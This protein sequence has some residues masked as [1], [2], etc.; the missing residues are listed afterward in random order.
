MSKKK[1]PFLK[2]SYSFSVSLFPPPVSLSKEF[3]HKLEISPA[4]PA[5]MIC[6][7]VEDV[8]TVNSLDLGPI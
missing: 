7:K 3:L 1:V 6:N 4:Q 5:T 2:R 8:S